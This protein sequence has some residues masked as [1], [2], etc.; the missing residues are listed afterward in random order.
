MKPCLKNTQSKNIYS[1]KEKSYVYLENVREV[2]T[3]KLTV[4]VKC[5]SASSNRSFS[6]LNFKLPRVIYDPNN[7][8]ATAL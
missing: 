1:N 3:N 4:A 6:K 2:L 7:Q 8:Y 5:H